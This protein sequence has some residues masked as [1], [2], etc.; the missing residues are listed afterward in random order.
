MLSAT[1]RVKE[2]KT[3]PMRRRRRKEGKITMKLTNK[4]DRKEV[5]RREKENS[6]KSCVTSVK[7]FR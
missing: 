3:V 5:W 2:E 7:I 1:K 6:M 4:M